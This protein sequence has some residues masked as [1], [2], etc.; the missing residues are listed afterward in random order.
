VKEKLVI[1]LVEIPKDVIYTI[2]VKTRRTTLEAMDLVAFR[3]QKLGQVR[4][5]LASTACDQGFFHF[6]NAISGFSGNLPRA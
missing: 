2:G 1:R 4:T 6:L 3:E 5:I